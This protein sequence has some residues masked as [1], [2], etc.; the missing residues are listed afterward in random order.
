ME[1]QA[2]LLSGQTFAEVHPVTFFSRKKSEFQPVV[3]AEAPADILAMPEGELDQK[4]AK[5]MAVMKWAMQ[6]WEICYS[7]SGGKDSSTVLS[8]AL[9]AAAQ[10][11]AEG[12]EVKRFLVLNSDTKV[13]NPEVK[14]V[15]TLELARVREWI[16]RH[17]L[18]GTVEVTLPNVLAEWAVHIIGGQTLISTPVTNR[19]CT[20]D[21]KTV[22]LNRARIRFFGPNKVAQGKFSVGMT[23]VRYGES[24]ERAANMAKRAES[25]TQLVQTNVDGDVYLAPIANWSTDDVMEYIGLAVNDL[26]PLDIY[27]DMK[28]VW[29]IYKDAAGE[30]TV[31]RGDKPS[32]ACGARHGC[33][34]CNM[35]G[36]DKS[37]VAF[38]MQEQYAYMEPLS[39]FREY[40]S[41]TLFDLSKRAWMGRSIVDGYIQF[42]PGSYAPE[43]TQDLL[44]FALTIDRDE[45]LKAEELGIE[46]RFQIVGPQALIAIDAI[47]S[48]QAYARPFAALAIFHDVYVKGLS[49]EVPVVPKAV[50]MPF[51][52]PRYIPVRD[53]DETAKDDYTGLRSALLEMHDTPTREVSSKGVLRTVM[54]VET[55]DIFDVHEESVAM[56]LEFELERLVQRYHETEAMHGMPLAGEA[57]RFYAQYGA[58]SLAKSQV[59]EVDRILRRS[60]WRERHGLAGWNFDRERALAMSVEKPL[61]RIEPSREEVLARREKEDAAA[62]AVTR[63]A[64]RRRTLTL[65]ELHRHWSPDVPWRQLMRKGLSSSKLLSHCLHKKNPDYSSHRRKGWAIHHFVRL[66]TLVEFLKA[67]PDIAEKVKAHRSASRRKGTQLMLFAA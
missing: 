24:A 4:I 7:Y 66:G 38:L 5:A 52:A 3:L 40:L 29:R 50:K 49:F 54:Q 61:P 27:T 65:D 17:E 55:S 51:P 42:A 9:A 22:P 28:D 60:A 32:D 53:W 16:A 36:E 23:G 6:R 41:N 47:W 1:L 19:N 37:M 26:L 58:I 46:P 18:P 56:I 45:Q 44:R 31:G 2:D 62:R 57:Y 30:C 10:L 13:E 43:Y 64:V 39:R 20:T 59:G 25:P 21:L 15:A 34:V 8:M 63:E 33:Y 35:V 48:L 67:N 14:A 11:K 12:R